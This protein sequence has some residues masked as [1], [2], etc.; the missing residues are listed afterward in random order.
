VRAAAITVTL[1][2]ALLIAC[3]AVYVARHRR[4]AAGAPLA[5]VLAAGALGYGAYAMELAST[6]MARQTWGDLKYITVV[7]VTLAFLV[8]NLAYTGHSRWLNRRRLALLALPTGVVLVLLAVPATHGWVR[9]YSHEQSHAAFGAAELG[10]A[11][12]VFA[13]YSA[14]L[15]AVSV[16]VT[17]V[18]LARISRLY[19]RQV[20]AL[21]AAVALP[22]VFNL[23]FTFGIWPFARFDATAEAFLLAGAVLVW[24][25]FRFRLVDLAPLAIATVV[26]QM[27]EAVIVL[28]SYGRVVDLNPA[29][30]AILSASRTHAVGF[31]LNDLLGWPADPSS[32]PPRAEISITQEL[33][34]RDYEVMVTPLSARPGEVPAG[35]LVVLRDITERKAAQAQLERSAHHDPLTGL[36]NRILFDDRFDL[37]LSAARRYLQP[38]AVLYLDLDGFK[39]VNDTFGHDAGDCVLREC[40]RRLVGALRAED[41]VSR[42]GGDE[43][44]VLLAHGQGAEGALGAAS[45]VLAC[46]TV[47][48]V[49]ASTA[50]ALTASIGVALWPDHGAD[51]RA[52]LRAADEAMYQS[53]RRGGNQV[54]VASSTRR[55]QAELI[56]RDQELRRALGMHQLHAFFQPV[57]TFDGDPAFMEAEL[58]WRHPHDGLLA[59]V[60]FETVANSAGLRRPLR[61][62]LISEACQNN[63][64][65]ARELTRRVA[66]SVHLDRRDLTDSSLMDDVGGALGPRLALG[67]RFIVEFVDGQTQAE[68]DALLPALEAL[69]EHNVELSLDDFGASPTPPERL[70]HLPLHQVKLSSRLVGEAASDPR[71]RGVLANVIELARDLDLSVVGRGGQGTEQYRV[72]RDLGCD[73]V[74]LGVDESAL[75]PSA[76]LAWLRSA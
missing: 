48:F 64:E 47:P 27:P 50:V 56:S 75:S 35:H 26:S 31:R 39:R 55:G 49:A 54:V 1:V 15:V 62:L 61:R 46:L 37:A 72:L 57:V 70:L 29:S 28:D 23:L 38:L 3:L 17:V 53:K 4:V 63:D 76:A 74:Q 69:K 2:S 58:R 45:K 19:H 41:T 6:G 9:H 11:G 5:V 67:H 13:C 43:F 18:T 20:A 59:P 30:E 51:Q 65:W 21:A 22:W 25:V 42:A 24:G 32:P 34:A 16:A 7:V 36:P 71:A 73:L 10:P 12:V 60:E 14:A 40:A 33:G 52:L 8:F 68:R 44:V 66:V